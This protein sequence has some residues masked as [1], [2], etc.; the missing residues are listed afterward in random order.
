MKLTSAQ[1]KHVAKLANLPLTEK[2]EEI[3]T[4]QLSKILGYIEQL[5]E[6]NTDGVEPI[7]NITP[8]SNVTSPDEV[9]ESLPQDGATKNAKNTKDGFFVTKGVFQSE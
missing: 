8:T 9:L 3:Y 6:V 2:E 7:F 5:N 4:E 1:V